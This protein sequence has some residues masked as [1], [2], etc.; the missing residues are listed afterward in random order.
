MTTPTAAA[1]H[2]ASADLLSSTAAPGAVHLNVRDIDA[3]TDFYTRVIGL[4]RIG[5]DTGDPVVLGAPDGTAIVALHDTPGAGRLDRRRPGL[6]HLAV[7]MPDRRELAVAL[8]RLIRERYPLDGASDHLVSEA[9]YL[10]DPEGNGIEI[11]RDRARDEWRVD[12]SGQVAM[13]TLPLDLDA[14]V[15]E[16][17]DD[18][19]AALST[20]NPRVPA[21]TKIG[22][23]HLQVA[24]LGAAERF[25]AGTIGFDVTLRGF[26]GA[27]F[28]SAGGYHHHLGLNTWHS[29]GAAP[30]EPGTAGLRYYEI[31]AGGDNALSDALDRLAAAG[32]AGEPVDGTTVFRDPSGNGVALRP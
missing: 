6:Y 2:P 13:A 3:L 4:H 31:H 30:P 1:I 11:Y 16:L 8:M 32:I 28:L 26:P 25:Y 17:G 15:G 21:G 7:L 10:S 12:A 29:R 18:P 27:L 20:G 9:L 19:L 14:L 22:H 23:V 5:P 24:D